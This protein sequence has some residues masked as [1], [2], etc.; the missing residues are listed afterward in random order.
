ME[1]IYAVNNA[2][3]KH[4]LIF[5]Y[6]LDTGMNNS[7]MVPCFQEALEIY[8]IEGKAPANT[9]IKVTWK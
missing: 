5:S 8:Q 2:F 9:I 4:L 1:I 3:I 6:V 7:N